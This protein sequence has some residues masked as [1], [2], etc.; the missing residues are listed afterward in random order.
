ME[1]LKNR[2]HE[3]RKNVDAVINSVGSLK[4]APN[5]E[6]QYVYQTDI[7]REVSLAFTKL[8]EAK[9]WLGK[10]LEVLGSELP[11]EYQDKAV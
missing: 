6:Q 11:K 4:V 10:C 7:Q 1:E 5:A 3:E 9:M 8:Q 2:L